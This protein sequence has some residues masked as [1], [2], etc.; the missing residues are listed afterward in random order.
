MS[1]ISVRTHSLLSYHYSSSFPVDPS[2]TGRLL[3]GLCATFSSPGWTVHRDLYFPS[4]AI[5]KP[6]VGNLLL[7]SRLHCH[8]SLC[9][10]YNLHLCSSTY[11]FF[12]SFPV[13]FSL[14]QLL[15]WIFSEMP[16]INCILHEQ[17]STAHC[18]TS[19]PLVNRSQ[20]TIPT[21]LFCSIFS[22]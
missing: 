5:L 9:Y 8:L 6:I 3:Q 19:S 22:F 12:F 15:A 11:I 10:T 4:T 21:D 2:D 16:V 20:E 18:M 1:F 17:I 13:C 7:Q 14:V